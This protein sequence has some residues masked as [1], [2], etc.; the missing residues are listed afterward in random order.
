MRILDEG[1]D[2]GG[3]F[4]IEVFLEYRY[5]LMSERMRFLL[6]RLNVFFSPPSTEWED[7]CPLA[8]P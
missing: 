3:A 2:M 7:M 5:Q 8:L 4:Y 1:V 6:R